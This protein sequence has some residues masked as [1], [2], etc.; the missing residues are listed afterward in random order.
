MSH[1]F[2]RLNRT[3]ETLEGEEREHLKEEARKNLLRD[4]SREKWGRMELDEKREVIT[5][6]LAAV[7]VMPIPSGV[8]SKAPFDPSLLKV[9]WRDEPPRVP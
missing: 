8:S 4:W 9:A 5:Q 6:V 7:I 3:I 1:L 2:A